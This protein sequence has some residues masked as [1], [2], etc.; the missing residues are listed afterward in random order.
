MTKRTV[1]MQYGK[2][3][4]LRSAVALLGYVIGTREKEWKVKIP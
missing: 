4:C 3:V 2:I 1:R